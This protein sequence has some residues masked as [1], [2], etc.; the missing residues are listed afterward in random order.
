MAKLLRIENC[1][2]CPYSEEGS[3]YRIQG[4]Y[5]GCTLNRDPLGWNAPVGEASIPDWCP[6]P[7][8]EEAT[9]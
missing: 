7:E 5:L 6:L 3:H 9:E 2:G 4:M 1:D 8:A